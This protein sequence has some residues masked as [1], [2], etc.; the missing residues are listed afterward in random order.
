MDAA[1]WDTLKSQFLQVKD[2]Q[3][4][5]ALE[6]MGVEDPFTL[7]AYE[8]AIDN[9]GAADALTIAPEHKRYAGPV[10]IPHRDRL[11]RGCERRHNAGAGNK[12]R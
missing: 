5:A 6:A 4:P 8:A 3:L 9:I 7:A 11:S 10:R 2:D 12:S 1:V